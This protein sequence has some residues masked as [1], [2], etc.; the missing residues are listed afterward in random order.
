[1]LQRRR[2]FTVAIH[3]PVARTSSVAGSKGNMTAAAASGYRLCMGKIDRADYRGLCVVGGWKRWGDKERK[4][5]GAP[6]DAGPVHE[7]SSEGG[8]IAL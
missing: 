2:L 5:R 7:Q 8:K 6:F 1:M 3:T 4:S